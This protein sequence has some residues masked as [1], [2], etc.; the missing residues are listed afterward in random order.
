MKKFCL[1]FLLFCSV[2]SAEATH[3]VGGGF[4]YNRISGNQY[5][6]TLTLYFDFINGSVGAKDQEVVCHIF[7]KQDNVY[8]DS[9][10]LPLDDS[11]VFLPYN[12]PGCN[13]VTNLK[14][15]VL[16]YSSIV[17]LSNSRYNSP[18]GYYLIWE[19]CCR[20]HIIS[21]IQNPEST[22][23]TFYME[24]PPVFR[25]SQSFIN[26]SPQFLPITADFPCIDQDFTL[27]FN[28][29]DPDGDS[30]RYTLTNPLK[31]NSSQAIPRGVAPIP[32]PYAPVVWFF[33]YSALNPIQGDPG[34]RVNPT[35]G[36]LSCKAIET[37]LFVF[38]VKCEEF[39]NGVKIG[40]VRREMQMPVVDCP[41]NDPPEI[42]LNNQQ[43]FRL[44]ED[45]TLRLESVAQSACIPLKITDLQANTAIKFRLSIASGPQNI[46][47]SSQ[48]FIDL[49]GDSANASFCL[50]SCSFTPDGQPWKI[51]LIANDNGCPVS[52]SDTLNIYLDIRKKPLE[53]PLILAQGTF[54]D[55]IVIGQKQILEVPVLATQN[56]QNPIILSSRMILPSGQVFAGWD[57]ISLPAGSGLGEIRRKILFNGVCTIPGDG[58][59]RVEM[60]VLTAKC[61]DTLR[62]TLNQWFK[63]LS[64]R[65]E[66]K[67]SSTWN[68]GDPI[69]LNEREMVEFKLIGEISDGSAISLL[70][71]GSLVSQKPFQLSEPASALGIIE[72]N[73]SY[74]A[75][76]DANGGKFDLKLIL[77]GSFCNRELSDSLKYNFTVNYQG[78][79][80]GDPPNLLILNGDPDN[81][82]FSLSG[83]ISKNNCATEFDFV[84]IYNRWGKKVFFDRSPDFQWRPSGLSEG[85][86][87]YSL[88][89]VRKESVNGW[90]QVNKNGK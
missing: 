1:C 67:L 83:I 40:E 22:G 11:T 73:F 19:R 47:D 81:Q 34:L 37:G 90:L 59:F 31:G 12:N 86:Y 15:Q 77:K 3:I 4:A 44:Q 62:D 16:T 76:C 69:V 2:I 74:F 64:Q 8:M 32:G 18:A 51:R 82:V 42:I 29:I 14:T 26:N 21:N 72:R 80:L 45:D 48:Y 71:S 25:G 70:P 60:I 7:R 27:P 85:L 46:R 10:V 65:P 38:S 28:A 84:E 33:G 49:D 68:G 20:N 58:R 78:A 50:P 57:G 24:F 6:F 52:Y 35:T 39:R 66:I 75:S 56:Q 53:A 55:T 41:P 9:I 43:G 23:Q 17:F 87:F 61:Q 13:A 36:L 5:R 63:L 54:P 88:N 89:F 30:L 79:E